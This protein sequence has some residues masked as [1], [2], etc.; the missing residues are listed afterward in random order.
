MNDPVRNLRLYTYVQKIHVLLDDG[1]RRALSG[2]ELSTSQYHLLRHLA[3]NDNRGLTVGDCAALLIC[4]PSNATRMVRRLEEQGFLDLRGDKEDRRIVWVFLSP[5]GQQI[6]QQAALMHAES[7]ERRMAALGAAG[8]GQLD[9][10][11]KRMVELLE[12]DL[13]RLAR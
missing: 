4:T 10:E 13:R 2:I 5:A 6:Y 8:A 1:D 9:E 3:L 7:V 12:D 11:L